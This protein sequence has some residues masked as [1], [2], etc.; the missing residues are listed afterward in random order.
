MTLDIIII[1]DAASDEHNIETG[2]FYKSESGSI[3]IPLMT[4]DL[5]NSI[6]ANEAIITTAS[7]FRGFY[8]L[9]EPGKTQPLTFE[10]DKKLVEA[11]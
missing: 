3:M 10:S 11:A 4:E 6:V 8:A 9:S 7:L 5:L 1:L 2:T